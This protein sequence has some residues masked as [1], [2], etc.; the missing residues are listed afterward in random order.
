MGRLCY[1]DRSTHHSAMSERNAAET[2]TV[3][4][5]CVRILTKGILMNDLNTM[6]STGWSGWQA[7]EYWLDSVEYWSGRMAECGDING[8]R[9]SVQVAWDMVNLELTGEIQ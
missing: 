2:K 6:T 7:L 4:N 8:Y 3:L 5:R 9:A 1:P